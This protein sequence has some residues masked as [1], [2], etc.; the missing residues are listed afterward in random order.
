VAQPLVAGIY[1][2]DPDDLSLAATMP[3]FLDLERRERSLILGLWRAAR[4]APAEAA[5]SSGA[6]WSLFVSF[7]EGMETLIHALAADLPPGAARLGARADVVVRDGS[8][9]R[10]ITHDGGALDADAVVLAP[11]AHQCARLLRYLDPS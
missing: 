2:A 5:S 8:G 6:R 10:V 4:R 9:W 1:T 3:R 7:A 11:E